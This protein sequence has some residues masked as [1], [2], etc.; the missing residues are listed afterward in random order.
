DPLPEP[1]QFLAEEQPMFDK[2]GIFQEYPTLQQRPIKLGFRETLIAA[3]YNEVWSAAKFS[4]RLPGNVGIGVYTALLGPSSIIVRPYSDPFAAPEEIRQLSGVS[5]YTLVTI[6]KALSNNSWVSLSN[7]SIW[8]QQPYRNNLSALNFQ[9]R[10]PQNLYEVAGQVQTNV[11]E[12]HDSTFAAISQYRFSLGK[13]NGAWTWLLQYEKYGQINLDPLNND[14]EFQYPNY[15]NYP[16]YYSSAQI[17]H[18]DF[19]PHGWRQNTIATLRLSQSWQARNINFDLPSLEASYAVLD[20]RFQYTMLTLGSNL[21][22]EVRSYIFSTN[23][24]LDRRLSASAWASLLFNSDTR[25]KFYYRLTVR[26]GGNLGGETNNFSTSAQVTWAIS[27]LVRVEAHQEIRH[28]IRTTGQ[29][30]EL[31]QAGYYLRLFN[32]IQQTAGLGLEVYCTRTFNLF[33]RINSIQFNYTHEKAVEVA[34]NGK[35][36]PYDADF[37]P[38]PRYLDWSL[39]LGGQ[40]VFAPQS[41]IRFEL[42]NRPTQLRYKYATTS[43]NAQE[44]NTSTQASLAFI[45]TLQ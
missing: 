27:R 22:K 6:E 42:S 23:N 35:F 3:P 9:L 4:T 8:G 29:I 43:R 44:E 38:L 41:Q 14:P 17:Q 20:R 15:S 32:S 28:D 45:Y 12:A 36:I 13:V 7:A 5:D 19:H 24:R 2:G 26:E 11:A 34:E 33:A 39:S 18:R 40:W 1:R 21:K 30:P 25:K 37:E 10:E 31:Q 16:Y